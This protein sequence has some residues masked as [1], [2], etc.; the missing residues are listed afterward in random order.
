MGKLY[1]KNIFEITYQHQ[2]I[3]NNYKFFKKI[4]EEVARNSYL[5]DKFYDDDNNK[6]ILS[7]SVI[8]D[9]NNLWMS[10]FLEI[11]NK[12]DFSVD[13]FKKHVKLGVKFKG[14]NLDELKEECP[15]VEIDKKSEISKKDSPE[16][17]FFVE[18]VY[19][20]VKKR[21]VYAHIDEDDN[22]WSCKEIQANAKVIRYLVE[23]IDEFLSGQL[24]K[25]Y[26]KNSIESESFKKI[27]VVKT[28]PKKEIIEIK[29]K[30]NM[31]KEFLDNAYFIRK[32][33]KEKIFRKISIDEIRNS[34]GKVCNSI[35]NNEEHTLKIKGYTS[36]LRENRETVY[37]YNPIVK[38]KILTLDVE[39]PELDE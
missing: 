25:M 21:N 15:K 24:L 27:E 23:I 20:L 12:F 11:T 7:K 19:M 33:R 29:P 8:T 37:V 39:I 31:S 32:D 22:L 10:V 36:S 2:D 35:K 4:I 17:N 1:K 5:R 30:E 3:L 18:Q 13:D 14:I 9:S 34:D 28:Y 16:W 26:I 6:M 38:R